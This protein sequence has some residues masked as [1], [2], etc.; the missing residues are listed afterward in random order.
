MTFPLRLRFAFP[1]HCNGWLF[2]ERVPT[3]TAMTYYF[4]YSINASSTSNIY[5]SFD[6]R[7]DIT[8]KRLCQNLYVEPE[9]RSLFEFLKLNIHRIIFVQESSKHCIV[10]IFP[11][12]FIQRIFISLKNILFINFSLISV[13]SMYGHFQG[14]HSV[15]RFH[16]V[17]LSVQLFASIF[18][19]STF[20]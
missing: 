4:K 3:H 5:Q 10:D 7:S 6:I 2:I 8:S 15:V 11:V 14:I 9:T 12:A 19:R 17:F 16:F 20:S 18:K 13:L 1:S